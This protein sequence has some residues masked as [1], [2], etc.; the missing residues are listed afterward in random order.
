MRL[1]SLVFQSFES[2]AFE[3]QQQQEVLGTALSMADRTHKRPKRWWRRSE[4][5]DARGKMHVTFLC[6]SSELL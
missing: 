5:S 4:D 3:Q 6:D 1:H 2:D